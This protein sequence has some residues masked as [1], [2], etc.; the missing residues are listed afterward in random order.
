MAAT[1]PRTYSATE[2]AVLNMTDPAQ[3]LTRAAVNVNSTLLRVVRV[4]TQPVN[5][6]LTWT[7]AGTFVYTPRANFN[8][9][10]TFTYLLNLVD[11]A[12]CSNLTATAVINVGEWG[13]QGTRA[14]STA[15]TCTCVPLQ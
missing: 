15:S 4:V 11:G 8:G 13:L 12:L 6:N 9:V 2:D 5:G 10:D 1:Q 3:L 7:A 14:G